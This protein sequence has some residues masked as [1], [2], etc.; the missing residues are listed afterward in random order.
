MSL[1]DHLTPTVAVTSRCL[2]CAQTPKEVVTQTQGPAFGFRLRGLSGSCVGFQEAEIKDSGTCFL[3]SA[4]PG[5]PLKV[6]AGGKANGTV[7]LKPPDAPAAMGP[8]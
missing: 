4:S 1:S 2:A 6:P 8:P 3:A 5:N 7:T